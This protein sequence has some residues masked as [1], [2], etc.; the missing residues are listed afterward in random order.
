MLIFRLARS[1]TYVCFTCL[2]HGLDD[3]G[4]NIVL[5]AIGV[6]LLIT[7][8]LNL[9][10]LLRGARDVVMSPQR[11][12]KRIEARHKRQEGLIASVKREVE[13]IGELSACMD[14]FTR[15]H[16]R[17]V[18][19]VDG[20][21]TCEQDKLLHVRH[22]VAAGRVAQRYLIFTACVEE[23]GSC[24]ILVHVHLYV[25]S[26]C[27]TFCRCWITFISCSA[28]RTLPSSRCWR[29]TRMSSSKASSRT[30][31][32]AKQRRVSYTYVRN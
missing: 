22:S 11:R 14:A 3:K 10:T 9:M 27:R 12:I 16:T 5:A 15:S 13:V 21:E 18:L 19:S 23:L 1:R 20:L 29:S 25:L 6:I 31:R 7:V 28:S 26:T 17:L 32:S 2:Q 24:N 4:F 30:C 8:V